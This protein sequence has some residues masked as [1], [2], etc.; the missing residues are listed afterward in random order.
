MD[1][2]DGETEELR[3][4]IL[5]GCS[6]WQKSQAVYF[7][8][9]PLVEIQQTF[10][11][12]PMEKTAKR[13]R[14]SAPIGFEFTIK[15]YQLI[16]HEPWIPTYRRSR[17][18]IPRSQW[19]RYGSFR[20]TGEVRQ[21]WQRTLDIA[22]ILDASVI[23]FQCPP[24]FTPT[25]EHIH[26]FESFFKSIERGDRKLAWEPRGS[27]PADLVTSLCREFGLTHAV[28]PLIQLPLAGEF[29]YFRLHGGVDYQYRYTRED[30]Q[31]LVPLLAGGKKTFTLFNNVAMWENGLMLREMLSTS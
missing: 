29:Q 27:W 12:P 13:W 2:P 18:N 9:F 23:L 26:N 19:D 10:Y 3:P 1:R 20:P 28:D 21:A 5:V 16:T 8:H 31:R 6:G 14:E 15:A 11:Q 30:L 7:H 24:Q 22:S 25:Q 4:Q 17:L